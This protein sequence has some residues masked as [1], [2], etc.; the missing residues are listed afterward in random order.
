MCIPHDKRLI[1]NLG[2]DGKMRLALVLAAIFA[3]PCLALGERLV[4]QSPISGGGTMRTSQLWQDPTP[5][6][7]NLDGDAVCWEDF[8]LSRSASINHIE[9]WGN[10][11]SELGFQIEFWRQDPGTTA[12]QPLAV[13]D[14]GQ[15]NPPV[16]PESRFVVTPAEFTT[17]AGPGGLTHYS[18]DLV[19]PVTLAANDS[20]NPRWFVGIIGWTSQ[21]Y[22]P[23]YWAQDA[24]GSALTFQFIRGGS[25]AGGDRFVELH[26]GRA[27]VLSDAVVTP[28]PG[29]LTLMIMA[30]GTAAGLATLRRFRRFFTVAICVAAAACVAPSNRADAATTQTQGAGSAIVSIDRSATFDTLNY[31]TNGTHLDAFAE[32]G[33]SI[34]TSGNSWV[35]D[36]VTDF[37][38]FHGANGA[39][40][41]FYCPENGNT[42][43][44]TIQTTDS[45]K[46]FAAEFMYGNGWTTGDIYG[47]PW[48]NHNATVDW[49]T[50]NGDVMASSG[51]VGTTPLLEMGTILGFSDPAGFD[52][53]LVRSTI[54]S[55]GDPNLQAIALDNLHVQLSAPEPSMMVLLIGALT[56][57]GMTTRLTRPTPGRCDRP[58]GR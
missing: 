38:P 53:L 29:S 27:L 3:M 12:Y 45:S 42:D 21:A 5:A 50:W 23:W 57:L 15:G 35:G 43:W 18:I 2:R 30:A 56:V 8:T 10:G 49:Q 33:L 28:E 25:L 14:Y 44:V 6:G 26:E 7:N 36:G 52:R 48:G 39:D 40:R 1:Q 34:T 55:S 16:S 41:T 32:A 19:N 46:I 37:D 22:V 31:A 54:A 4:S 9:W 20:S 13:F 51:T 58:A 24:N 17:S 11:A 47:V